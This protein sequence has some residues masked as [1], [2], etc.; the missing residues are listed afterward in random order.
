MHLAAGP[1]GR[2]SERRPGHVSLILFPRHIIITSTDSSITRRSS[3]SFAHRISTSH[4]EMHTITQRINGVSAFATTTVLVLTLA[5]TI[6]SWFENPVLKPA[7]VEV[8]EVEV[9]WGH[10]KR[11]YYDRKDRQWTNIRFGLEADFRPLFTYNTKQ[12]FVFLLATYSTPEFPFNEV[13]LWDR[14]I[15]NAR[16]AKINL[17]G[18]RN[19][20]AF[21][22]IGGS[23]QN[24]N[25][26]YSLHYNLMPKVGALK[27][28]KAGQTD[29]P[30]AFP[31]VNYRKP[32]NRY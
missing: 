8:S 24:A 11:D 16:D 29:H 25:A 10:D 3:T 20:Y 4:L 18:A 30:I 1:G 19:K 32:L 28:G 6:V 14:I 17:S 15:K 22:H 27:F 7:R 13:V 9:L 2:L 26:T 31:D 12:I 23:F 5:I 21:K